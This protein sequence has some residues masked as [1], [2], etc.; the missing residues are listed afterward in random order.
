MEV[1]EFLTAKDA[2]WGTGGPPVIFMDQRV[3]RPF[4]TFFPAF[5]LSSWILLG[6]DAATG[7]DTTT[8]D[9]RHLTRRPG[10][11]RRPVIAAT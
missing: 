5:L 3:G 7:E 11:I 8:R 4:P 9:R 6:W 1:A 10:K 2:K